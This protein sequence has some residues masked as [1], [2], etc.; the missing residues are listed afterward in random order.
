MVSFFAVQQFCG[1]F[2]ILVYAAQFSIEA[3]VTI[4]AF[5]STVIVGVIRCVITIIAGFAT[6]KL[7]RRPMSITSGI[8]M[9]VSMLGITFCSA[10]PT[11]ETNIS[12]LP[13][14]FLYSFVSSGTFAFLTLPFAMVAE[15]FEMSVTFL[16]S[17]N[18]IKIFFTGIHKNIGDLLQASQC[19]W[20]GLWASFISKYFLQFSNI[21]ETLLFSVSIHLLRSSVYC[22]QLLFCRKRKAKL[23]KKLN[24]ILKG[25]KQFKYMN[26]LDFLWT[27]N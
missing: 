17:F 26:V 11:N 13:A 10:F 27:R 20:L 9:F 4:D 21:L 14:V 1:I 6:V 24:N 2:V 5:L 16:M 7:G 18:N 15:M 22:L 25:N 23:F 8:G 12:W 19:L 3:G